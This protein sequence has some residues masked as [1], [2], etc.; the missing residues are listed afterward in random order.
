MAKNYNGRNKSQ[1]KRFYFHLVFFMSAMLRY[2][3][4]VLKIRD[5]KVLALKKVKDLNEK[6][7]LMIYE[8]DAT[9]IKKKI[10]KK[11]RKKRKRRGLG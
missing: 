11:K 8:E 2:T 1:G 10:V 3:L 9:A 5:E 7:S 6:H 4:L